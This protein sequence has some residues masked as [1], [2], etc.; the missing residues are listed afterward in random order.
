MVR[1]SHARIRLQRKAHWSMQDWLG[2]HTH[3]SS[4]PQARTPDRAMWR[5][6]GSTC[7]HAPMAQHWGA[8]LLLGKHSNRE[9]EV[10]YNTRAW[11]HGQVVRVAY[12]WAGEGL[13][14]LSGSACGRALLTGLRPKP[15]RSG[16]SVQ[17]SAGD[18]CD[19]SWTTRLLSSPSPA[20][21]QTTRHIQAF[22]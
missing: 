14:G 16:G 5:V 20:H 8:S 12:P 2:K 10:H 3:M 18:T 17:A 1:P 21:W 13:G 7:H 6:S 15:A 22:G 19:L 4:K 9:A 11:K